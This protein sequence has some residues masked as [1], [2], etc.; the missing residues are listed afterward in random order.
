MKNASSKTHKWKFKSHFR[1]HV[2]GWKSSRLAVQRV[3]QAVSE[4]KKI[5]RK[6]PNFAGEGAVIFLERLS[7][8]L[9]RVDSSSGAI[10]TVVHNAIAELVP[11]I[12]H[13]AA[14]P[15]VREVWIERLFVAQAA[16]E[17]P[18]LE[19]LTD[20]WGDLCAS[21]E[22]AS[23]WADRLQHVTR[24]AL[25][26]DKEKHGHFSGT[27]ACLSALFRAE[28][29]AEIIDILEVETF[30]SYKQWAVKALAAMGKKDDAI[31]YA[32]SCRGR[33]TSDRSVD[34]LCEEIL[35]SDVQTEEAYKHY[36]LHANRCATNLATFRAVAKKYP[37]KNA[38]EILTDLVGTTPCE[39]GKWFAAAKHAGLY[40]KAIE[41]ARRT[42]CD[43][44]TLTRAARDYSEEHPVFALHAGLLAL[45]WLSLDYGYEITSL[46]VREAYSHTIK[47]AEKCGKTSET[48]EQI[49]NL[50]AKEK[51]DGILGRVLKQKLGLS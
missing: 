26:P 13:A 19:S 40:D 8:A 2:F 29:Y 1:R 17:I 25:S 41:L 11:I 33:W 44:K 3:K 23:A 6:D 12:A 28:R 50:I 22:L 18:Y 48:L 38:E 39:E 4:I 49:R 16:D 27:S 30:W 34:A 37:H 35:L 32:E 21:Q 15:K 36:G 9:E 45:Y 20:Y 51:H 47:A 7:S 24:L 42:P 5:A 31:R 10:G 46:D 14:E 43:P